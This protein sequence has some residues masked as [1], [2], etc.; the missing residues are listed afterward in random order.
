MDHNYIKNAA[1]PARIIPRSGHNISRSSISSN[2]LKVLYRL[3]ESGYQAFL[4]GG[5]VRD[6]LL[7]REPK[8][9]DIVTDAHPEQVRRVFRNSRLIGRRFRLAHVHFGR[10]YIEVATFRAAHED[11]QEEDSGRVIRDDGRIL[12][13][14]IYGSIDEDVWR[15]DFTVNAL[16][17][18]ISDF[19]VWDYTDGIEDIRSGLLRLIG[20]PET[21]YREDPVRMLRAIRFAAKL[22]FRIE[23]ATE[24]CIFDLG[25]LLRE[26]AASRMF[27]ELLKMF[28]AGNAL[29]SFEL[30]NHYD[31]L[32]H[33][34][35][36]TDSALSDPDGGAY[37]TLLTRGLENTDRRVAAELPVTPFFLFALLLW[38]P[39]RRKAEEFE[40][41]GESPIQA[42]NLASYEIAREQQEWVSVPRRFVMPM[43]ELMVMQARLRNRRGKKPARL[44]AHPRFRAAYDF[45]LLRIEAGEEDPELGEWWT[46][47]QQK[48]PAEPP[49]QPAPAGRRKPRRR[50]RRSG[51]GK[52]RVD[53]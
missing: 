40:R 39:V 6:L 50:R 3:K 27:D 12:R 17:Y 7:G 47:F 4:V 36:M 5:G 49:A 24:S 32:R 8:D 19:S 10:E 2:A 35:P 9:F 34:L 29:Q 16:Y 15:R 26:V 46:H 51:A 38:G 14:N 37:R 52:A 45:L 44:L 41:A 33:I 53:G 30:L 23:S 1:E 48:S 31:L 22:G 20:D 11:L 43:R 18:N 25:G 21:R 13:D 28:L 42:L